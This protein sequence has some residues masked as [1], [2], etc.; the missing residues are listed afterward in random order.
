MFCDIRQG[1][2]LGSRKIIGGA[3][4]LPTTAA[5]TN[6]DNIEILKKLQNKAV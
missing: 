3:Y 6:K 1:R 4:Q 5:I 2:T